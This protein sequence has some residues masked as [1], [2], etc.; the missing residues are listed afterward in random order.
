MCFHLNAVISHFGNIHTKDLILDFKSRQ[1]FGKELW[2]ES[3]KYNS[4]CLS[5]T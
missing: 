3:T 4:A 2:P 5:L 1:E